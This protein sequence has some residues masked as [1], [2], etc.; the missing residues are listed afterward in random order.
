VTGF[1]SQV[2][3]NRFS[4]ITRK[5]VEINSTGQV[6]VAIVRT[7]IDVPAGADVQDPESVRAMLSCHFGAI[8]DQ[9]SDVGD[10]QI[11]GIL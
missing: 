8:A 2:P 7:T 11:N 4:Y 9:S 6:K 3:M 1:V 10:S 5:G